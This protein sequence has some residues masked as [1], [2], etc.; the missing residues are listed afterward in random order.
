MRRLYTG[1]GKTRNYR[2]KHG[3]QNNGTRNHDGVPIFNIIDVFV[4]RLPPQ[5]ESLKEIATGDER[6]SKYNPFQRLR[7][8]SPPLA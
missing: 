2:R 8:T 3:M 7:T 1:E 4:E 5:E 6:I